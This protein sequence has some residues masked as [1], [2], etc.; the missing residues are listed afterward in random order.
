MSILM[1]FATEF[2]YDVDFKFIVILAINVASLHF[3]SRQANQVCT[4]LRLQKTFKDFG[5][6]NY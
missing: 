1:I 5:L 4:L 2:S 6:V 3:V